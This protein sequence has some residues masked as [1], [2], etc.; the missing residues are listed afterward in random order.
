MGARALS[1]VSPATNKCTGVPQL[2]SA[3]IRGGCDND[4]SD[5]QAVFTDLGRVAD[6]KTMEGK[7]DSKRIDNK[8]VDTGNEGGAIATRGL[9]TR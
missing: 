9:I 5:S 4:S 1:S 7:R 3:L 6:E 8:G 2:G